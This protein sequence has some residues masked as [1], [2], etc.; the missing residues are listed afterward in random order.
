MPDHTASTTS[1]TTAE[2]T[3]AAPSESNGS[4]PPDW[5][6]FLTEELKQDQVVATWAEK[7]SYKDVQSIIKALAHAQH[8]L[9]N[10]IPVPPK[11]AKPEDRQAVLNKL[12]DA[13]LLARPPATPEGYGIKKPES[14][15]EG[16]QWDDELAQQLAATLHKHGMPAEAASELLQLHVASLAKQQQAFKIEQEQALAALK[17][18]FGEEFESAKEQVR[19]IAKQIFRSPEEVEFYNRIGLGNHPLFLG[20][21]MRIAKQ[22][23]A[24]SSYAPG[25]QHSQPAV[26]PQQAFAEL[27]AISTDPKHPMYA[28]YKQNDPDVLAYITNLYKAAYETKEAALWP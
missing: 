28:R 23:K 16:I 22:M 5:R 11:D 21:L 20:P 7:A 19:R 24:D 2:L 1:S 9:G 10:V 4:L 18:E 3:P 15:P 17:Q 27:Q 26:T 12:Y 25:A 6:S 8:K 14:L 13:G